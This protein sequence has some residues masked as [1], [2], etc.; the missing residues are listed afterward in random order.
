MHDTLA[1][2]IEHGLSVRQI[3]KLVVGLHTLAHLKPGDTIVECELKEDY[4]YAR[5][6]HDSLKY[7]GNEI[8][9]RIDEETKRVFRRF[10]QHEETPPDAG[11]WMCQQVPTT[12]SQVTWSKKTC[13]LAP[14][15]E[16]SVQ[17]FLK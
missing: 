6:K 5:V 3:P 2:I 15:L 14:T 11:Y 7:P 13:H 16:E 9:F 17:L 1:A 12:S 8:H 10:A 4:Q